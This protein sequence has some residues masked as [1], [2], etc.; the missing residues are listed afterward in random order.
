MSDKLNKR[1]EDS[2]N[3]DLNFK[4]SKSLFEKAGG[5]GK[6]ILKSTGN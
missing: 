2:G 3:L 5:W 4:A 6:S 1:T